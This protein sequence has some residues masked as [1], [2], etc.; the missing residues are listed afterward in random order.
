MPIEVLLH[1]GPFPVS[2]D[3]AYNIPTSNP[4]YAEDLLHRHPGRLPTSWREMVNPNRC[5]TEEES[6]EDA[7]DETAYH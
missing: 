7:E 3:R 5:I 6:L 2:C 1:P 4:Y